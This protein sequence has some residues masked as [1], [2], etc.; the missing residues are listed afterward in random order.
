MR[1]FSRHVCVHLVY[2]N[3]VNATSVWNNLI[4]G[5]VILLNEV[6]IDLL[7]VYNSVETGQRGLKKLSSFYK[8][9]SSETECKNV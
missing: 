7:E 5:R 8:L 4:T 1:L 2:S 6:D 3:P 9:H